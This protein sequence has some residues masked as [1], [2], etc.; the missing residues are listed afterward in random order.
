MLETVVVAIFETTTP[1]TAEA[2]PELAQRTMVFCRCQ[3]FSIF[4]EVEI[5]GQS[6]LVVA[7]RMGVRAR[8]LRAHLT[9][10]S[11]ISECITEGEF[12]ASAVGKGNQLGDHESE[13]ALLLTEG[14]SLAHLNFSLRTLA[15]Y[16]AEDPKVAG[17]KLEELGMPIDDAHHSEQN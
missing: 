16:A 12:V 15:I 1:G 17:L 7:G 9:V 8:F 2:L 5:D 4:E 14:E 6:L 11:W 13:L 3:E 10:N